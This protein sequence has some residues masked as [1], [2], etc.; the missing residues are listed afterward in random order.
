M[1]TVCG[2]IYVQRE[3]LIAVSEDTVYGFIDLLQK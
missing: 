1:A 2:F 3:T